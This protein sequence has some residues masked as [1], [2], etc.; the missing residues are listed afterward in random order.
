MEYHLLS[1]LLLV[2]L[3][4]VE[5][6]LAFQEIYRRYWEPLYENARR[7]IHRDDEAEGLVQ[8]VFMSIWEKRTTQEIDNLGGYLTNALKYRIIDH[9]RTQTLAERYREYELAK[10]IEDA[11]SPEEES[12]F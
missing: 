1:D 5:D 7:K 4:R 9:Y 6:E 12:D 11:P 2:K 8:D 3:L 10:S